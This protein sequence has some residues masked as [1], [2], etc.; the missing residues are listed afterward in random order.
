MKKYSSRF[1]V[2]CLGA[3]MEIINVTPKD[4]CCVI[5]T[6]FVYATIPLV[7]WKGLDLLSSFVQ[8]MP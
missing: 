2:K 6:V 5:K 4:L 8:Q 1:T 3:V 7:A